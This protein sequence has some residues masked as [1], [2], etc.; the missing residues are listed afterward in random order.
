MSW[1]SCFA[2]VLSIALLGIHFGYLGGVEMPIVR[3]NGFIFDTQ[4]R[5]AFQAGFAMGRLDKHGMVTVI[6][7]M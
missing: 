5:F 4:G 3:V 7:N 2:F 1:H 6:G